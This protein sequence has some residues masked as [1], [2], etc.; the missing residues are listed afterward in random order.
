M[1]SE[2]RDPTQPH[3]TGHVVQL[4]GRP[5]T[6]AVLVLGEMGVGKSALLDGA[7]RLLE[8]AMEPLRLHGS[9][10]LAKVPYGVLAP[11]LGGLPADEAG[12]RVQVLRAFWRAVETLRR[13]RKSDLLLVID[14]AHEL[15]PASSEVVAELVS[16]RWT[17]ALVAAPSGAALPRPL[18]ELWLDG[19][20]E[21]VDL[22]PLS[23]DQVREFIEHAVGGP[24]LP[25][26]L[27]SSGRN[28]R[29]T[30]SSSAASS[31]RPVGRVRSRSAGGPGSS[32]ASCPSGG[33]TA[34]A[35]RGRSWPA[36]RPRSRTR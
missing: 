26:S 14:D 8:A 32:P 23:V 35:L 21:R 36:S 6:A 2:S 16:A 27:S 24:V 30:P 1:T 31:R 3:E 12:S 17:K 13:N 10:A 25:R 34:R 22:G 11:F 20:V 9:P 15:D 29:A 4:I 19:G 7:C 28:R 5:G 33:G 18:M